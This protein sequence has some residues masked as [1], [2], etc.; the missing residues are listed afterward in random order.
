M[1]EESGFS[2]QSQG[3]YSSLKKEN[4]K[5]EKKFIKTNNKQFQTSGIK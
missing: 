2:G 4:D 3:I 1:A 5:L